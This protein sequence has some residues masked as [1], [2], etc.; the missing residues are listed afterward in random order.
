MYRAEYFVFWIILG[1]WKLDKVESAETEG[2]LENIEPLSEKDEYYLT[3]LYEGIKN[4]ELNKPN[5]NN[6]TQK[7]LS[8]FVSEAVLLA[9]HVYLSNT[10]FDPLNLTSNQNTSLNVNL[11]RLEIIEKSVL[12]GGKT[13]IVPGS[14]TDTFANINKVLVEYIF[15]LSDTYILYMQPNILK[16]LFNDVG[17]NDVAVEVSYYNEFLKGITM[18]KSIVHLLVDQNNVIKSDLANPNDPSEIIT[19]KVD[20]PVSLALNITLSRLQ[21]RENFFSETK[22]AP[23]PRSRIKAVKTIEKIIKLHF[24]DSIL[25]L[26]STTNESNE[27]TCSCLTATCYCS[28]NNET[29]NLLISKNQETKITNFNQ[30]LALIYRNDE[31]LLQHAKSLQDSDKSIIPKTEINIILH[32]KRQLTEI[33]KEPIKIPY[34]HRIKSISLITSWSQIGY[35]NISDYVLLSKNSMEARISD[36]SVSDA[37]LNKNK[38]KNI[39][40]VC[41]IVSTYC[42]FTMD[43]ALF[44]PIN[45]TFIPL[46]AE[47][48]SNENSNDRNTDNTYDNVED[49][50]DPDMIED[51]GRDNTD[52][53]PENDDKDYNDNDVSD[54]LY[55]GEYESVADE[56]I[57]RTSLAAVTEQMRDAEHAVSSTESIKT[58]TKPFAKTEIELRMTKLEQVLT[59]RNSLDSTNFLTRPVKETEPEITAT[60][61]MATSFEKAVTTRNILPDA[62]A[63]T[64]ISITD[65]V[66]NIPTDESPERID[67]VHPDLPSKTSDSEQQVQVTSVKP[68]ETTSSSIKLGPTGE[69]PDRIDTVQPDMPVQNP[70]NEEHQK[71]IEIMNEDR[72]EDN[73]ITKLDPVDIDRPQVKDEPGNSIQADTQNQARSITIA[74]QITLK[75]VDSETSA[76]TSESTAAVISEVSGNTEVLTVPTTNQLTLKV[77]EESKTSDYEQQVQVTSGNPQETT[78]SS[79]K[80]DFN[81]EIILSLYIILAVTFFFNAL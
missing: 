73:E 17:I 28:E 7:A 42:L 32:N 55:D 16:M 27:E 46:I 33:S 12:P 3:K 10:E 76:V 65:S 20:N 40:T 44:Y 67:T 19:D 51:I 52:L 59:T 64:E 80:L 74:E 36:S 79:I 47:D 26:G 37:D 50:Y 49:I 31:V 8:K 15:G 22:V 6:A 70:I 43:T 77:T 69:S 45:A 4:I 57:E 78:S 71:S 30:V 60:A 72:P 58:E 29:S 9:D 35:L 56:S 21:I 11:K 14:A 81:T 75:A 53:S 2:I 61:L 63:L 39:T 24:K 23:E 1:T 18:L 25:E 41:T 38:G 34:L 48:L 13:I 66:N 62:E 5:K 68:Q 54:I